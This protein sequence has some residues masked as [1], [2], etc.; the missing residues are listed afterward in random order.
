MPCPCRGNSQSRSLE[1]QTTIQQEEE[2]KIELDQ[3][4]SK[5]GNQGVRLQEL[6]EELQETG[7]IEVIPKKKLGKLLRKA[8]VDGD[9][10]ITYSEFIKLYTTTND[11]LSKKE[12]TAMRRFVGAAIHNIVPLRMREDFLQ[13]YTCSPPP[14]FMI[15]VSLLEICVFIYYA[16]ELSKQGESITAT[17]GVPFDS[18]LIYTPTRRYEAWR[19]ISYMF[20]HQGYLHLIFNLIFQLLLGLP[21]EIVHK[22]WRLLIVYLCG[23]IGGSLGHSVT[24]HNVKLVGA[25]GGCYALIG[26]H[27]ASVI[28]NWKEMNYKCCGDNPMRILISAPVRLIVM[29]LFASADTGTAIYRRFS[30][31]DISKDIGIAAHIGGLLTGLLLGVPLMKNINELSWEK[32][33]GWVTLSIYLAALLFCILFNGLYKGYPATDWTKCC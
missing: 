4:F 10:F 6:E 20:L 26:A 32:K 21:L 3:L 9:C 15:I 31:P 2:F 1:R 28:V 5:H 17:T 19:Y 33:V 24:D 29:S 8:D 7:L 14:V 25:S 27:L 11:Q 18:P 16:V 22:W 13:N 23:V 12:K 30:N